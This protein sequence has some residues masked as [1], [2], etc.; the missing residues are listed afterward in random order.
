MIIY[1]PKWTP[2]QFYQHE[3]FLQKRKERINISKKTKQIERENRNYKQIPTIDPLSIDIINKTE[4]YI[5]LIRRSVEYRAQKTYK[6]ILNERMNI[7][8]L[9]L[10]NLYFLDKTERD[11]IYWRQKLWKKKVE[12]KLNKSSYKLQKLKEKE[13]EIKKYRNY[14]LQL[15]PKSKSMINKNIK[16]FHTT[17]DY[18]NDMIHFSLYF[19]FL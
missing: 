6:N 10:N 1:K 18:N 8:E 7:R 3:I 4:S 2:K 17:N 16:Y 19:S 14:K 11:I 15:C 12:Q 5:P 9:K 13:E